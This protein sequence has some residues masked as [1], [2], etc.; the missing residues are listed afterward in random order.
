MVILAEAGRIPVDNPASSFE[1]SMID[2]ART[3]EYS[4]RD[5]ALMEWGGNMKFFVLLT[6]LLDV[7]TLPWGLVPEEGTSVLAVV[8]AVLSLLAKMLLICLLVVTI[9]ST[10]AKWRFFRIPEYLGA[11]FVL[12]VLA[13]VAF[14][15]TGQGGKI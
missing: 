14:Y 8:I 10:V 3:L 13:L 6:I 5:L 4:G 1:L 9:E 11:A 7:L 12:A 2:H 15:L